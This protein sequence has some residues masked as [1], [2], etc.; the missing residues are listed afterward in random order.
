MEQNQRASGVRNQLFALSH[1][2]GWKLQHSLA[3]ADRS[4]NGV[5]GRKMVTSSAEWSQRMESGKSC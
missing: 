5:S 4:T 1:H 3:F 2:D